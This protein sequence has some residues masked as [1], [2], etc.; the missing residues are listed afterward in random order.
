MRLIVLLPLFALSEVWSQTPVFNRISMEEGLSQSSVFS[1]VQDSTG[2]LWI[3]TQDG[4]N[5]YDGHEFTV[6]RPVNGDSLSLA[7][8][9]VTSL[10]TDRKDRLWVGT[11]QRGLQR[12][13]HATGTFHTVLP[14]IRIW[15]LA[16]GGDGVLWAGTESGL[17]RIDTDSGTIRLFTSE[18]HPFLPAN[19]VLALLWH[20]KTRQ[21]VIGTASGLSLYR[22]SDGTFSVIGTG[23]GGLSNSLILS[24]YDDHD[25]ETLW[26]G[27]TNGLNAYR[28][29]EAS[30]RTWL[31]FKESVSSPS[32]YSSLNRFGDGTIRS[33]LKDPEGW[34]WLG[35]DN[36][37][38]LLHPQTGRIRE[39][40]HDPGS[41]QSLSNDLVRS[42]LADRSGNLWVGTAAGGLSRTDLKK[43]PFNL[44]QGKSAGGSGLS[45][46]NIR[47][48]LRDSKNRLWVGT[49]GGG[50]NLL[51]P[52]SDRFRTYPVGPAS[53]GHHNIWAL[54]EDRQGYIW[55]GTSRGANRLSPDGKPAG[56]WLDD[57][58]N[59]Q[60]LVDPIV[61]AILE[62]RQNRLWIGTDHGVTLLDQNRRLI[63]HF[64]PDD[65]SG[66][67]DGTVF[68]LA[69]GPDG[70]IW[71]AT[72]AGLHRYSDAAGRFRSWVHNPG[73]TL[74]LSNSTIRSVYVDRQGVLWAGS[75]N[76]LNRMN[77]D[78]STFTRYTTREGLINTYI[79]AVAGDAKNRIWMSTNLG[80]IRLDPVSGSIRHFSTQHGLQ[81]MEF[82]TNSVFESPDGELF[83]GGING[84]NR[85]YPDSVTDFTYDAPVVISRIHVLDRVV[86]ASGEASFLPGFEVNYDENVI[87]VRASALDFTRPASNRIYFFLEGFSREWMQAGA[88]GVITF[89]NLDPGT[90]TLR[91]RGTNH[92]GKISRFEKELSIVVHPPFW[93][94]LWFRLLLIA[95][96]GGLAGLI[97]WI[98]F[99]R[100]SLQKIM[101]EDQVRVRTRELE[102][103]LSDLKE[104]QVRL[105]ESEKLASVGQLTAGLAHEMN[106]PINFI[107]SGAVIIRRNLEEIESMLTARVPEKLPEDVHDVFTESRQVLDGIE[108]GAKRTA[109]IVAD[110]RKFTRLDESV[111]K[112][113]Y[114]H[115]GLSMAISLLQH[116]LTPDI[117]IDTHFDKTLPAVELNHQEMNQVFLA[118]LINAIEAVE[119]TGGSITIST[120][121]DQN[122]IV[123]SISDTG[124][125]I[126]EPVLPRVFDPFF[127]TKPVGRHQ[128][129]GLTLALAMVKRH[130]GS[131]TLRN[132][133]DV[134][135]QADITIPLHGSP[136]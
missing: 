108:S 80:L 84:F 95:V 13:H 3:G 76:G 105:V 65:D 19:S 77:P 104:A 94:T 132:H 134:G 10:L 68:S 36:G 79:Y 101:L 128:G 20:E 42:L 135:I 9:W 87:T 29:K 111:L 2:F 49:L 26:I 59:Q 7:D 130:Q 81:A 21:L 129:M 122:R 119:P 32:R 14:D 8:E 70:S 118:V 133:P 61:R 37:L 22:P 51:E 50:L 115:S 97:V 66:L 136:Q 67:L 123:I 116:R 82:N 33:I 28:W 102:S 91:I 27:T 15:T 71:V 120:R 106:N 110:L 11:H 16:T 127:T 107:T 6:F 125:G 96:I 63:R 114:V 90:F 12:Y 85:F 83:F 43:K 34:L 75:N 99:R 124:P 47:S 17:Y 52:E 131:L 93:M 98:R 100:I 31:V 109:A 4:L 23:P 55:V 69:E 56:F 30:I 103:T 112:T 41:D 54:T 45:D 40:R 18:T 25:A 39:I 72:P 44:V 24:L 78:S 5:R 38:K 57:K 117:R 64:E 60:I 73:D 48:M 89:T 121:L 74:S 62:D 126:P 1:M 53:I 86:P 46:N 35:T 113:D 92:D 58:K 88:G